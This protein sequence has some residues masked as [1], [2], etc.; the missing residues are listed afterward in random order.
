MLLVGLQNLVSMVIHW[1]NHG[2][3]PPMGFFFSEA[4]FLSAAGQSTMIVTWMSQCASK[5]WFC[6]NAKS[7]YI[8]G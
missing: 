8:I 1:I 3:V 2:M 6:R 4:V 7:S 5:P